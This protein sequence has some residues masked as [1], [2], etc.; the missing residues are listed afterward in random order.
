MVGVVGGVD[1]G[2]VGVVVASIP[3]PSHTVAAAAAAAA[4][5]RWDNQPSMLRRPCSGC[6]RARADDSSGDAAAAWS[7]GDDAA[8]GIASR[9]R[10]LI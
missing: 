10:Q 6:E 3:S 1:G 9:L 5:G 2:D 8:D 7:V 4:A